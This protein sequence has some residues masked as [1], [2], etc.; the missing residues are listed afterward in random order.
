MRIVVALVMVLY[1]LAAVY[2]YYWWD[3]RHQKLTETQ[4][5]Q[6]TTA[7][8]S[9]QIT[10]EQLPFPDIKFAKDNQLIS[11]QLQTL[12]TSFEARLQELQIQQAKTLASLQK[13][14]DELKQ[15]Q[16]QVLAQ[17]QSSS[18]LSTQALGSEQSSGAE[19]V[20]EPPSAEQILE[21]QAQQAK[22]S[23]KVQM[24]QLD[25]KLQTDTPDVARQSVF[26]QKAENAL[27]QAQLGTLL[28]T[29]AECGQSFC[30][31][32]I[33]GQVP[34]GVDPLQALWEQNVFPESTEVMTVPKPDGSGWLVY[35]AGEGQSL[36]R[37]P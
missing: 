36:S 4:V 30:K 11:Q 27:N 29:H 32:D 37:L 3:E 26:Q 2:A 34:V 9:V 19:L 10:T 35:I 15:Q 8:A 33:Q 17:T 1:G 22:R 7:T 13:Q 28:Q 24:Q 25:L 12:Q 6:P 5:I 21:H 18:P 31:L 16:T 20:A 23:L 14:I